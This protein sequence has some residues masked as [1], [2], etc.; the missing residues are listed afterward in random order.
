MYYNN[1]LNFLINQIKRDKNKELALE[2]ICGILE[3]DGAPSAKSRGHIVISTNKKEISILKEIFRVLKFKHIGYKEIK[4]S[5]YIRIG[6]IEIIKNISFLKD[7]LFRYYPKRR[8][9]LQQRLGQTGCAK[10]LLGKNKKTSNWLIGQ[11]K[12]IEF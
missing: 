11:L 12:K 6:S 7:K 2:F 3:G 9:R 4:N 10:Y 5:A 1:L 8:K